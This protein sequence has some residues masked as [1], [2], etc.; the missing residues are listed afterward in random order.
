KPALPLIFQPSRIGCVETCLALG[1]R[2]RRRARPFTGRRRI[3]GRPE[4]NRGELEL[5]VLGELR[6]VG[7]GLCLSLLLCSERGGLLCHG[8]VGHEQ[9]RPYDYRGWGAAML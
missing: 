3:D 8:H 5:P 7:F 6:L 4:K 2:L 1:H 9:Q